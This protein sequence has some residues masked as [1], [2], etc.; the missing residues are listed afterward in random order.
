M[1][2]KKLI[3]IIFASRY[4]CINV[5]KIIIYLHM[6]INNKGGANFTNINIIKRKEMV[7]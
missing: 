2:Q 5:I 6:N 1:V 7:L 4:I 3:M